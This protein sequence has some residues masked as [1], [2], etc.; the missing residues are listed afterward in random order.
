MDLKKPY[1]QHNIIRVTSCQNHR[2]YIHMC[3]LHIP[4]RSGQSDLHIHIN[5]NNSSQ[6][7]GPRNLQRRGR[8]I[9][10]LPSHFHKVS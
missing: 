1:K 3:G 4:H 2:N 9:T 8:T 5:Y 6:V 7:R 10:K